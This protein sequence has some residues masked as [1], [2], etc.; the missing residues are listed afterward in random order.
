MFADSKRPITV[1]ILRRISL[2]ALAR[3]RGR[4]DELAPF[5]K[6]CAMPSGQKESQLQLVMDELT[7]YRSKRGRAIRQHGKRRTKPDHE[8]PDS[9][10]K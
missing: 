4:L 6:E 5:I 1:E 9:P 7:E 3:R 2:V 8:S 10:D